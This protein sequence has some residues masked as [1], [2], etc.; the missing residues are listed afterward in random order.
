MK[1]VKK[2]FSNKELRFK[3]LITI[4]IL[5]LFKIGTMIK[6]PTVGNLNNVS[7]ASWLVAMNYLSGSYLGKF[8]FLSLGLSPYITASIVIQLLGMGVIPAFTRWKDEGEAGRRKQ[9]RATFIFAII[10]SLLEAFVLVYTFDKSYK[11]LR[12]PGTVSYLITAACLFGGSVISMLMAKIIDKKGIGNGSSL[13]IFTGIASRIGY[14]MF[15]TGQ[16]LLNFSNLKSSLIGLGLFGLYLLFFFA[17]IAFIVFIDKSVRNINIQYAKQ[18]HEFTNR[19]SKIP[20]KVNLGGV[21][22]VIFTASIMTGLSY[23]GIFLGKQFL[24]DLGNYTTIKGLPIYVFLIMFFSIFYAS[25]VFNA[26][27]IAKNV[28]KS[29]AV[30]V[31]KMP[32]KDTEEYIDGIVKDVAIIG[33][34]CLS[35]IAVL[36][37]IVSMI[38][39]DTMSL[40]LSLGG[41][42][43]MILAGVATETA[44]QI[45][46]KINTVKSTSLKL[47]D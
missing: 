13:I 44:G 19:T 29:N 23:L 42:S 26:K 41:T 31:G 16:Q 5:S 24:A 21:I 3:V 17:I 35:I 30:V 43:M 7:N 46:A 9:E 47:F 11:V 18:S 22:P 15:F 28:K 8:T 36:P 39:P 27:T 45:K 34:V 6:I 32:G 37:I 20:V 38:T 2:I 10:M 14:D 33:G 25:E 12:N 40:N 4:L 1:T